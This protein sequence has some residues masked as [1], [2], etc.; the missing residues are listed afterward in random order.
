VDIEIVAANLGYELESKE[1]KRGHNGTAYFLKGGKV[2]KITNHKEEIEAAKLIMGS[3]R[4]YLA[5]IYEVHEMN[6]FTA[7]VVERL[8]PIPSVVEKSWTKYQNFYRMYFILNLFYRLFRV[9]FLLKP[10]DMSERKLIN[11]LGNKNALKWSIINENISGEAIKCGI[12]HPS[13]YLGIDNM[14]IKGKNVASF[15]V[16][17]LYDKKL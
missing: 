3:E 2:L 11:F 15:D 16:L 1:G 17:D 4:T 5:D 9:L 13:D 6:D 8:K 10:R 12:L 14:G 7:I